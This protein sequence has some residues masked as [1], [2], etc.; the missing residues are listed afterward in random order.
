MAGSISRWA[1]CLLDGDDGSDTP[2]E[3]QHERFGGAPGALWTAKK[4]CEV[5]LRG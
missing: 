2:H 3:L 5:K 1:T 4:Q